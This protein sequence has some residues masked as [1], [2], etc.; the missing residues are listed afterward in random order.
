MPLVNIHLMREDRSSFAIY[1]A[2][3]NMTFSL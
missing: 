3:Q 2:T 1:Q